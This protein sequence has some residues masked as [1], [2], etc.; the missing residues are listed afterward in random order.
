[1]FIQVPAMMGVLGETLIASDE[2]LLAHLWVSVL[3]AYGLKETG[4]SMQEQS[5]YPVGQTTC[6]PASD[7]QGMVQTFSTTVAIVWPGFAGE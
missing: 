2:S 5:G 7:A 1:M 6:G 4:A 3:L